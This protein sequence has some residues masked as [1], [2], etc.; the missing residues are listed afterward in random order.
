MFPLQ[1]PI[2]VL[3]LVVLEP[4]KGR[5]VNSRGERSWCHYDYIASTLP[6][7]SMNNVKYAVVLY[8]VN[9][10]YLKNSSG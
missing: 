9:R 3:V 5:R 10:E 4:C 7:K 8:D 1:L 6:R 2:D